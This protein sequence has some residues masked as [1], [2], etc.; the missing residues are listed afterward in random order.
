[1]KSN[2]LKNIITLAALFLL[3]ACGQ[4]DVSEYD[5]AAEK[6]EISAPGEAANRD[7]IAA[8]VVL[9]Q[10][11]TVLQDTKIGTRTYLLQVSV[12]EDPADAF[13]GWASA[14]EA[15]GYEIN[16]NSVLSDGRL[17]F[18]GADVESGQIT[19]SQPEGIEGYMIQIDVSKNTQ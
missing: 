10:P 3:V 2:Y 13:A 14:L 11:H 15:A 9:P 6:T 12:V 5:A 7:W 8:G 17:M 18:E 16:D 4:D 1:M 19:V